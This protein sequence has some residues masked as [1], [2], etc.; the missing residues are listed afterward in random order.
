MSTP[1][2]TGRAGDRE[3]VTR[4]DLTMVSSYEAILRANHLD[5]LDALFGPLDAES[6]S[7]PGL[8]RW[9]ERLRLTLT[10]DSGPRTFYL[11]RFRDPPLS[12]GRELR[13]SGCDAASMAGMEWAWM[14]RLAADGIPC[15][16]PVAFGEERR[17]Q[18]EFRSAILT[19]AVPGASLEYWAGQWTVND[20][21]ETSRVA[22][23]LA[24]LIAD[25]HERGY[26]HRDLYLSHVFYDP[27]VQDAV[28]LHLIDLQRVMAPRPRSRR[29][30]IKDLASLN[31]SAPSPVL[32]RTDRV[33]W[34]TRYLGSRKLDGPARRL[35]YRIVGKTRQIAVHDRRRRKRWAQRDVDR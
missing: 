6:L 24:T 17:G 11:K 26:V 18:K 32:S 16:E 10:A 12:A 27:T 2:T 33:R 21:Q 20:R 3:V 14:R 19:V 13:R 15:V 35:I 25:F 4:N 30:V 31:F 29:W 28:C 34:L 8:S 23:A 7:K 1:A 5:S 9:R 22:A